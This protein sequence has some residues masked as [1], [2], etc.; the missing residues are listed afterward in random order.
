MLIV[1]NYLIRGLFKG[2]S[3]NWELFTAVMICVG[4][5]C[6]VISLGDNRYE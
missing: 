4:F 2:Y 1:V 3:M 6:F 5:V